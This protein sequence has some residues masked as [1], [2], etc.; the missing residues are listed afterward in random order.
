MFFCE[1]ESE[2]MEGGNMLSVGTATPAPAIKPGQ[3]SSILLI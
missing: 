3:A 1:N 2:K